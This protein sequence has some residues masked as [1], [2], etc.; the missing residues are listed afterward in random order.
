MNHNKTP[1]L[2]EKD[3]KALFKKYGIQNKITIEQIKKWIWNA[4]GPA[5]EA[6]NKYHKKCL[7]LFPEPED[8]DKMNDVLQVF[9]AAW[10][11]F[12]H[13]ELGGKSPNDIMQEEMKKMP[14]ENR[15]NKGMPK[16]RVGGREMEWDD[17][18]EMLKKM[19]K[20]QKPF[21]KWIDKD[22]MPKYKKYLKQMVKSA[23]SR[24]SHYDVADI[25][26]QRVLHVGFVEFEQIRP[27]FIQEE[28]PH[29]WPTHVMYSN[30]KPSQVRKSLGKLFTFIELVYGVR[31]KI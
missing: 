13:K 25:F 7:Q 20:A 11:Y 29:W 12:P 9:V 17:F 21:K 28:F 15:E 26:F 14:K 4:T 18:Q 8:I 2:V 19:E 22:V 24:E 10:N 27:T 1:K 31:M 6:S 30:L 23:R 16:V 5:M 3:L